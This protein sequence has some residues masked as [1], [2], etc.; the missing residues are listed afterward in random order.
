VSADR[1]HADRVRLW[2]AL[3]VRGAVENVLL[4]AFRQQSGLDVEV[5]FD[6]TTVL[7]GRIEAGERPEV[8]VSTTESLESLPEGVIAKETISPLIR[9]AI[10][11]GV[12]QGAPRPAI[13]TVDDVVTAL[14]SARSVAYSRTG[15]SGIYFAALIE[16]LGIAAEIRPTATVLESGFVG[17]AVRDGRADLAVQQLSELAFVPG[18][19]IVGP[20]PEPIQRYT[21]F[22]VAIG[23]DSVS[24]PGARQLAELLTS[25]VARSAYSAAGLL[26]PS[27]D[28]GDW[29]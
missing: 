1:N 13:E 15:Q 20:L 22:S 11:L 19:D 3:V 12:A 21:D 18:I 8:I 5:A 17:E 14:R 28:R 4:P 27:A 2:S 25:E 9:A 16:R 23:S 29:Q 7:M 26:I 10:G 6:P 24:A